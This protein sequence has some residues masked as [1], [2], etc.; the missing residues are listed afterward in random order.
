MLSI[1]ARRKASKKTRE[2]KI[3]RGRE[4][5]NEKLRIMRSSRLCLPLFCKDFSATHPL[6]PLSSASDFRFA[7][8]P[9]KEQKSSKTRVFFDKKLHFV[10]KYGCNSRLFA[11]FSTKPTVQNV[12][13][14]QFLMS[15]QHQPKLNTFW[16]GG[17]LAIFHQNSFQYRLVRLAD[18]AG[19]AFRSLKSAV[20]LR[21]LINQLTLNWH[22]LPILNKKTPS[23]RKIV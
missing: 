21:E 1:A 9:S 22:F 12:E 15:S 2:A 19:Q 11:E 17:I 7:A 14:R 4:A 23:K 8:S 20:I 10:A 5:R 6:R 18:G 13:N 3:S 16:R